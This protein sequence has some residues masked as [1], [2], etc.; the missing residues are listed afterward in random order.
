[1]SSYL[2]DTHILLWMVYDHEKLTS[3]QK[4]LLTSTNNVLYLSEISLFE[5]AIKKSIGKLSTYITMGDLYQAIEQLSINLLHLDSPY[6]LI[7]EQ[8]LTTK[9]HKDPF[10]RLI[11]ATAIAENLSIITNDSKFAIYETKGLIKI[12]N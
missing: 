9:Q 8:L 7:Y 6:L 3:K 10:D 12:E 4:K 1:M 2:I 11:I 5:I